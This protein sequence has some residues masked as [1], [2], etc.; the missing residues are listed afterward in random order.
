MTAKF[1]R[2]VGIRLMTRNSKRYLKSER[3]LARP[4]NRDAISAVV[5]FYVKKIPLL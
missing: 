4:L 1:I 3:P 2:Q 5:I